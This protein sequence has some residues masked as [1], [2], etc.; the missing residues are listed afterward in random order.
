MQRTRVQTM[1]P[2]IIFLSMV[3]SYSIYNNIADIYTMVIVG[4]LAHA[5]RKAGFMP[6]PIVLGLILGPI[7][8]KGLAQSILMG[9]AA[10][11]LTA[12]F[13]ARPLSIILIVLA[14]ASVA[15]PIIITV[16]ERRGKGGALKALRS[17]K[18]E[19]DQ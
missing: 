6:G 13:F 16:R 10:G 17:L 19:D 5:L 15:A 7:A 9:R 18:P 11:S 12:V 4:V 14:A 2:L 8:E 1:A 3:G